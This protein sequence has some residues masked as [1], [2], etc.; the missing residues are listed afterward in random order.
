[1]RPYTKLNSQGNDFILTESD[2]TMPDI[3]VANIIKYSSRDNIG[4]DQF[5]IID[6][7]DKKN[8]FCEVYNQDGS[9]ACQ[10]GNG[11]RATMLFLNRKYDI[12]KTNLIVCGVS[13]EANIHDDKISINMGSPK[14]VN[15]LKSSND[16]DYTITQRDL[17]VSIISLKDDIKFSFIPLSIG[18]YHCI[19][20]SENCNNYKDKICR[21]LDD[22]FDSSMNIGFVKNAD[23]FLKNSKT[24]I[25]LVVNEKGAGYTKSCGSGAT[26]AAICMFKIY[27]LENESKVFNSAI[28]IKQEGGILNVNKKYNPDTFELIGPSSY[29]GEGNLE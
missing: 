18:N 13:Y 29:D 19:V 14:Y 7:T 16:I 15:I 6:T 8:I 3:S 5:F 25:D 2:T 9:K 21:I 10:C 4:C 24:V 1:M 27:E 22:L 20:F 17:V 11:L 26:A 28:T 12:L 23:E